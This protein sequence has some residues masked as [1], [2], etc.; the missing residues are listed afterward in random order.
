MT[1]S[2]LSVAEDNY[3]SDR[4]SGIQNFILKQTDYAFSSEL[5]ITVTSDRELIICKKN[6][7]DLTKN[8]EPYTSVMKF[9]DVD[10][11]GLVV[12]FQDA[13]RFLEE[14]DMYRKLSGK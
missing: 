3:Q 6:Y 2:T 13:K 12:F 10:V 9:Q 1:F 5:K 4:I 7:S 11:E 8:H 14:E